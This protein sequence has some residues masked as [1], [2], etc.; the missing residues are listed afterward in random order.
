MKKVPLSLLA[1]LSLYFLAVPAS[2]TAQL[3]PVPDSQQAPRLYQQCQERSKQDPKNTE[4]KALCD[5]GMR[6]H[7]EGKQEEAIR[8]IQE[9][10]AKFRR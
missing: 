2:S 5:E 9:G 6:L 1:V 4:A 10:L 8:T 3:Q 7:R